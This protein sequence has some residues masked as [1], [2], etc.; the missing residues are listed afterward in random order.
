MKNIISIFIPHTNHAFEVTSDSK[1]FLSILYEIYQPYSYMQKSS[2]NVGCIFINVCFERKLM[3]LFNIDSITDTVS[4]DLENVVGQICS[5]IQNTLKTEY[6]WNLYHGASVVFNNKTFLFFGSSETGK[7]T[8]TAYLANKEKCAVISEDVLIVNFAE[9]IIL[10]FPRALHLRPTSLELLRNEYSMN[11]DNAVKHDLGLYERYLMTPCK[12]IYEPRKID[13]IISLNRVQ[14]IQNYE[15]NKFVENVLDRYL[16]SCFLPHNMKTNMQ[17][18]LTLSK[19]CELHEITYSDL[20]QVV[21]F[22]NSV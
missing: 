13:Y 17:S 5:F 19:R 12:K 11:M 16:L 4:F 21:N 7:T 3:E 14:K 8:L 20:H 9:R 18:S 1:M 2:S 22:L 15:V 10:P 6:P